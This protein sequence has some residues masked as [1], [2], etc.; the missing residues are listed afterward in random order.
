MRTRLMSAAAVVTWAGLTLTACATEGAAMPTPGESPAASRP[1]FLTASPA[2][3]GPTG[4]ASDLPPAKWAAL[5]ADLSARGVSGDPALVSSER[6]EFSDGS[7]GC[8]APGMAYTQAIVE[9]YR[10]VVRVDD[11]TF[12]YRFGTGDEPRLCER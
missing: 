4:S 1:P 6:V 5:T 7:L 11:Q 3:L 2:P 12:D 9:G 8:P 10:V